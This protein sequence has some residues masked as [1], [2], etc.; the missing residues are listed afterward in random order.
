MEL[1]SGR[2]IG[3]GV[4]RGVGRV[5]KGLDKKKVRVRLRLGELALYA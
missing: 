3:L 1:G 5:G 4:V 2:E